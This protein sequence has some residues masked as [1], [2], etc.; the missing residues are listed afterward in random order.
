MKDT[1]DI[2]KKYVAITDLPIGYWDDNDDHVE[3]EIK[4]GDILTNCYLDKPSQMDVNFGYNARIHY[5]HEKTG[6]KLTTVYKWLFAEFD[7]FFQNVYRLDEIE[8]EITELEIEKRR[9]K[10]KMA[11]FK[12]EYKDKHNNDDKVDIGS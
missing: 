11:A 2:N 8:G 4:R 10:S 6:L 7:P 1:L 5:T 3:M 12:S 9:L